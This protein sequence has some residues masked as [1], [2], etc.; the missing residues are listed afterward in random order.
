MSLQFRKIVESC[1]AKHG[2]NLVESE[3]KVNWILS[4]PKLV[5]N[6]ENRIKLDSR[7][8]ENITPEKLLR[9][10]DS[11]S[12]AIGKFLPWVTKMYLQNQFDYSDLDFVDHYLNRFIKDTN[13]LE[14]KDINQYKSLNELLNALQDVKYIKGS[15]EAKRDAKSS[16]EK[17]YEDNK[18]IILI[19]RTKEA[20]MY[21][22]KGTKWC[23]SATNHNEFNFY[24]SEGPLYIIINKSNPSEKYQFHFESYQFMNSEDKDIDLKQFLKENPE[25]KKFFRSFMNFDKRNPVNWIWFSADELGYNYCLNILKNNGWGL[26][27]IPEELID[28][29]MCSE[30]IENG[31]SALAFVPEKFKDYNLCLKAVK[32]DKYELISVPEKFKEKIKSEL[33]LQ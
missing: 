19:P 2:Y 3:Q 16:A 18:W 13:K 21:Y 32:I 23:T 10:F 6:L 26:Q 7:V 4:Q 24:N 28:Y 12:T 5:Q 33:G 11:S 15:R 30:V 29:N 1:L 22:G 25:I 17:V 27:Y 31:D 14:K 8:P 9:N 20:A